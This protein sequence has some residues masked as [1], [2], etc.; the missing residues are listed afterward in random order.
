MAKMKHTSLYNAGWHSD[1]VW[2]AM[3]S[4]FDRD[5]WIEAFWVCCMG[6]V[7]IGYYIQTDSYLLAWICGAL[8]CALKVNR[9]ATDNIN[10]N[11]FMHTVDY[12][13]HIESKRDKELS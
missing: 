11:W 3:Q 2:E 8:F 13:Q 12:L 6:G 10:R 5:T 9:V 1:E 7:G 4:H